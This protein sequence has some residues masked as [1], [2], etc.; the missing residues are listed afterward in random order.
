MM[1]GATT[2][3]W[4]SADLEGGVRFSDEVIIAVG[5]FAQVKFSTLE[6]WPT[7]PIAT[8]NFTPLS[9]LSEGASSP[10]HHPFR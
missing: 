10:Q 8:A 5:A 3:R 1:A 6:A 4:S 7:S 2:R 9:R